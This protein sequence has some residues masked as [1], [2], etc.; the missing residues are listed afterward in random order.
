VEILFALFNEIAERRKLVY[1]GV[2]LSVSPM[3]LL[4]WL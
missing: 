3:A 4:S 2:L 1:A